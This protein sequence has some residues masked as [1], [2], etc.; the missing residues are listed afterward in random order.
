MESE[1]VSGRGSSVL[2]EGVTEALGD[3]HKSGL[4]GSPELT[5]CGSE[6]RW[7]GHI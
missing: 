2:L 1:A 3:R 4:P 5:G 6:A 7:E